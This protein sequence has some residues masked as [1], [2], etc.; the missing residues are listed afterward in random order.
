MG[1]RPCFYDLS[2][3]MHRVGVFAFSILRMP[4]LGFPV[5]SDDFAFRAFIASV[6][7]V[8]YVWFLPGG[9]GCGCV[10]GVVYS[11][12]PAFPI[13]TACGFCGAGIDRATFDKRDWSPRFRI[14]IS[15]PN[16]IRRRT[17]ALFLDV[18]DSFNGKFEVREILNFRTRPVICMGGDAVTGACNKSTLR[19]S[20]C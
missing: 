12:L 9:H 13:S 8:G 10:Q 17:H 3:F 1:L 7:F 18:S 19:D 5:G 14:I 15:I 2:E 11:V 6:W 16:V 20:L 4:I